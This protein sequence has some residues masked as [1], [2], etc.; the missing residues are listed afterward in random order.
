MSR[1]IEAL[2]LC[3]EDINKRYKNS[4]LIDLSD[5]FILSVYNEFYNLYK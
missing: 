3:D 2:F 1:A 4:F 5:V